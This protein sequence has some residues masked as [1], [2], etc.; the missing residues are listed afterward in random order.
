MD[1]RGPPHATLEDALT[2]QDDGS[3]D[4]DSS[5]DKACPRTLRSRCLAGESS[6]RKHAVPMAGEGKGKGATGNGAD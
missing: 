3:K 1:Q 4:E 5:L 2:A 6:S